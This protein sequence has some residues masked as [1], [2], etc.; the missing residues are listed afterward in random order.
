MILMN[1]DRIKISY[2]K[3][4]FH[5]HLFEEKLEQICIYITYKKI[6]TVI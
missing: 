4:L 5:L 3:T 1:F 6:K 2:K